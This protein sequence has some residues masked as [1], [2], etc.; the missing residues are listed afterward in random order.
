MTPLGYASIEIGG[1]DTEYGGATRWLV[2]GVDSRC[3]RQAQ[4]AN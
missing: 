4:M 2:A 3:G 1:D